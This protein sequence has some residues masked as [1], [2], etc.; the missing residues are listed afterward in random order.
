MESQAVRIDPWGEG[1]LHPGKKIT[2]G[3]N[4]LKKDQKVAEQ[5]HFTSTRGQVVLRGRQSISRGTGPASRK[6]TQKE[7]TMEPD[8]SVNT[9]SRAL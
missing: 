9:Y 3:G 8:E 7:P 4:R 5:D 2:A 1:A 6:R